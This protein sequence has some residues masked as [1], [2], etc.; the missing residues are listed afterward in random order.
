MKNDVVKKTVYDKLFAK[1]NSINTSGFILK[2]KYDIDKLE[3][4][5]KFFDTRGFVKKTDYN[6]KITK[7]PSISSLATNAALT[8]VE[9]KIP[10]VSNLVKKTNYGMK[11]AEIE[12]K[13]TD[14]DHDK[15][16]TT[17]KFN[18]LAA[19]VFNARLA[20]ANLMTKT[21]FDAKLSSLNA[22]ITSNENELKKLKTFDSI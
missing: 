8:A 17:P 7:I 10:N 9:N 18:T 19:S 6:A 14:H 22:K 21:G 12:K 11:I 5:N 15:Y 2:T 16:I 4:E 13:F 3:I 1:V 20:Q